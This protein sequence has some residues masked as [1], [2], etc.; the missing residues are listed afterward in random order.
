VETLGVVLFSLE[1]GGDSVSAAAVAVLT[2]LATLGIMLAATV[3]VR[4]L[5]H[6]VLPWQA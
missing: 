2:V 6:P 1:Q 5:A 3:C 4:R